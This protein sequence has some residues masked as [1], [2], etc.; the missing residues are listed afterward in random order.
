MGIWGPCPQWDPW[1]SPLCCLEGLS[2][3]TDEYGIMKWKKKLEAQKWYGK[4]QCL[5]TGHKSWAADCPPCPIGS[6]A[7]DAAKVVGATSSEGFLDGC[8]VDVH[9]CHELQTVW[10]VLPTLRYKRKQYVQ[11]R[12]VLGKVLACGQDSAPPISGGT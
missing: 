5:P 9:A 11:R 7:N 2:P 4:Q 1:Q 12:L 10:V 6:A 8:M 3:E